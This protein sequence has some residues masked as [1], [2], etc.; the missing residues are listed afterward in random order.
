VDRLAKK[1]LKAPTAQA[2]LSKVPSQMSSSRLPWGGKGY[3]FPA[4]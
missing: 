2:S 1:A 3:R 4:E